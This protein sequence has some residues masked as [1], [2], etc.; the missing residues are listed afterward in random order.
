[1]N[2]QIEKKQ[3]LR[4]MILSY[5]CI[6]AWKENKSKNFFENNFK[7]A[8]FISFENFFTNGVIIK[9]LKYYYFFWYNKLKFKNFFL[10][11]HQDELD[12]LMISIIIEYYWN[13]I[14]EFLLLFEDL[15]TFKGTVNLTKDSMI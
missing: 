1:M 9:D 6:L 12:I 5:F 8:I 2:F 14:F 13:S 15:H 7:I 10:Q 4:N 3:P 11:T